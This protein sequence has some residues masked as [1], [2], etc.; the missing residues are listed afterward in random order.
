[1]PR[2]RYKGWWG[3][4]M[5]VNY[6]KGKTEY[7]PGVS[8]TLTGDEVATAIAAYLV[9]HGIHVNGPRTITVN[10]RLCEAGEV[11]V[12]PMGSVV[13]EGK[14]YSGRGEVVR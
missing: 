12:D 8:V 3:E 10:G 7:G 4:H 13:V 2:N 6:G 9:A 1:M 11:Y 14:R 5:Q